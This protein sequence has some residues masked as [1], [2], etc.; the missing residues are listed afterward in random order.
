MVLRVKRGAES[1]FPTGRRRIAAVDNYDVVE[2]ASV[3][4]ND[5]EKVFLPH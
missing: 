2:F 4:A 3:S 5:R 1:P